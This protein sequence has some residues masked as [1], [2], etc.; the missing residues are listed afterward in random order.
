MATL[1]ALAAKTKPHLQFLKAS[2]SKIIS[3]RSRA[4]SKSSPTNAVSTEITT[5]SPPARGVPSPRMMIPPREDPLLNYFTS[6]IMRHGERNKAAR[7]TTRMLELIHSRTNEPPLPVFR[8]AIL[9]ASPSVR[10]RSL[11][12]N[13]K[14]QLVPT[15]LSDKQRTFFAVKWLIETSKKRNEKSIHQRLASEVLEIV[16]GDSSV[17]KKKMEIHK[18]AVANRS[19]ATFKQG[20]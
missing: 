12:K 5:N 10:M 19:S 6:H 14:T 13:A 20:R 3:F 8:Q 4:F 9:L 2:T 11:K 16:K 17:L 18:V 1:T 15:P 7:I